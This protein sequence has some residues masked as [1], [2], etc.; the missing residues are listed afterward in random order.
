MKNRVCVVIPNWNAREHLGACLDSLQAQHPRPHIIV[1]DNGSVDG[2]TEL[3]SAHYPEVEL[4]SLPRNRGFAGGVNVGIRR[5]LELDMEYI[6]LFNNDAVAQPGWLAA[7]V[8]RAEQT[9]KAGIITG[10]LLDKDGSHFDSSGDQYSCWG[11]P[12][13]RGRG[14]PVGERYQESEEVFAA[15]GG[16]SLYRSTL[17]Q[18]I[19]LFDEDFFAYYEDIDLSW[20]A[21]L[22]G[23]AIIYEPAA[24]AHHQIGATSVK[25][26]GFTTYHT[27][28]NLPWLLWK[29]VPGPLLL[30]TVPRF[31]LAYMSFFI[32]ACLRG[33]GWPALRGLVVSAVLL[34]KKLGQRFK[35]QRHR[36][37]RLDK[38]VNLLTYDLPPNAHKLRRLR[39]GWWRLTGKAPA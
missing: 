7:L 28:K 19:G 29:N 36:H 26:K 8:S 32:S 24:K 23:W 39:A 34:P 25:I 22:A 18:E 6:A 5:A 2:S 10:A 37:V 14:E 35:I 11:L 12:Y 33:Q 30:T 17:L 15:S 31:S 1:V 3:V 20:R 38:L 27:M 21:R 9:P 16:A 4:L 13:P